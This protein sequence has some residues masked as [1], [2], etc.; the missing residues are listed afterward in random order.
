VRWEPSA[1]PQPCWERKPI[2]CH[3]HG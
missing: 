1:A 2:W 3:C